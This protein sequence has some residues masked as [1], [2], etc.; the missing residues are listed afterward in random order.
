M[1]W[2]T[3]FNQASRVSCSR[4]SM[5]KNPQLSV[6]YK[7]TLLTRSTVLQLSFKSRAERIGSVSLFGQNPRT[8]PFPSG[9]DHEATYSA[10]RVASNSLLHRP[11]GPTRQTC[12]PG[13][14][15]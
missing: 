14:P 15:I 12:E 8:I 10:I 1:R 3:S 2:A 5:G 13:E 9:A 4:A 7:Q 6:A 11:I